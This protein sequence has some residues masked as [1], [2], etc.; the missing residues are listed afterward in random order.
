MLAEGRKIWGA[1]RMSPPEIVVAMGV[2]TGDICR[3]LRDSGDPHEMRKE[4]GNLIFSTVRWCNDLGF[5]PE[6]C[7]KDAM[8][9]QEIFAQR[10]KKA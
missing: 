7:V 3:N 4:L 8:L 6:D 10:P 5:N 2:V 1:K 9:A